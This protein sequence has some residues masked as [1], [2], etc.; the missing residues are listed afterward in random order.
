MSGHTNTL[1]SM[2]SLTDQAILRRLER[3]GEHLQSMI[4]DGERR[5]QQYQEEAEIYAVAIAR[6]QREGAGDASGILSALLDNHWP[7]LGY[8]SHEAKMTKLRQQLGVKSADEIETD[9][10][11]DAARRTITAGLGPSYIRPKTA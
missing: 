2:L 8:V 9:N 1:T 3:Q 4:A 10:V 5:Q 11:D 7:S 6:V